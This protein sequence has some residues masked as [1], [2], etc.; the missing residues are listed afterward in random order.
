VVQNY[1]LAK[2]CV[3]TNFIGA[4]RVTEALLPLLQLSTSPRIVNVS[5]RCGQLKVLTISTNLN[6][7]T[8]KLFSL[9]FIF[10][11]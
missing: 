2:E 5:S 7:E 1:E 3:E 11:L 10:F 9:S 6:K 8:I 4:K